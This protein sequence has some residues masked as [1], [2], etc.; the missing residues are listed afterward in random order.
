MNTSVPTKPA[1]GV[2]VTVPSALTL[3]IPFFGCSV[4]VNDL[5]SNSVPK[6][7]D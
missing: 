2:K 3:T 7:P 1:S 6:F 4:M 5:G